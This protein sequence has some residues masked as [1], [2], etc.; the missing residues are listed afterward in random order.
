MIKVAAKGGGGVQSR[1]GLDA[2]W[3]VCERVCVWWVGVVVCEVVG[4]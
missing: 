2:R 4:V 3:S 1:L